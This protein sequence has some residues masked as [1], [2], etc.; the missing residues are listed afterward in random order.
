MPPVIQ[1]TPSATFSDVTVGAA[2][3]GGVADLGGNGDIEERVDLDRGDCE[4]E[5]RI[6]AL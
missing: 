2:G 6:A 1:K 5:S 3:A 4:I